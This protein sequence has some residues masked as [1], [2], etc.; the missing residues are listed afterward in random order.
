MT[1][2]ALNLAELRETM[3]TIVI[4][5]RIHEVEKNFTATLRNSNEEQNSSSLIGKDEFIN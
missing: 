3:S 5:H 1:N 4:N 2:W